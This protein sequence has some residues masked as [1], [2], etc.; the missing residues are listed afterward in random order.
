MNVNKKTLYLVEMA[1]LVA[2]IFIMAFTPLG[3]LNVGPFAI[4]F[5]TVPVAV[6]AI[7]LGPK[8]GAVCGLAFGITSFMQAVMGLSALGAALFLIN[9]IGSAIL[10]IVPRVLEGWLAGLIFKAT[11]HKLKTGAYVLASLATPLMNTVFFMSTLILIF[12]NTE[13]IQNLVTSVGATNPFNFVVLLVGVNGVVE[14]LAGFVLASAIS[15]GLAVALK[16][17]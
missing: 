8:G 7:I 6:G 14:A 5:L 3:Y 16:N 2:I 10:C 1:L 13:T 17:I 4:T 12:Y 15:K 9:P 11:V